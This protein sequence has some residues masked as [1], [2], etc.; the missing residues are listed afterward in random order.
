MHGLFKVLLR[1]NSSSK[2]YKIHYLLPGII[3]DTWV[4]HFMVLPRKMPKMK[5]MIKIGSCP[6]HYEYKARVL[7]LCLVS[8]KFVMPCGGYCK[9]SVIHYTSIWNSRPTTKNFKKIFVI[10]V[11]LFK[12]KLIIC[13][14]S[15]T[16]Q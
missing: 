14:S 3:I 6:G 9:L 15:S 8:L 10:F 7:L 11:G 5:A 1:L 16:V 4:I 12:N 2:K 13:L